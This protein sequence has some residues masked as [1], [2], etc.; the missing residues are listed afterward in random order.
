M[1][2]YP[3]ARAPKPGET[4]TMHNYLARTRQE[5]GLS[6]REAARIA[7]MPHSKLWFIEQG[8]H[9]EIDNLIWY[10][11]AIGADAIYALKLRIADL[12]I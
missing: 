7:G 11:E 10:C 1:R 6:L 9:C 2:G 12:Q 3:K 8:G 5:A 4:E